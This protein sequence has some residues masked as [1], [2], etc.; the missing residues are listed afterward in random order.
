MRVAYNGLDNRAG[1]RGY[2]SFNKYTHTHAHTIPPWVD[3]CEWHRM[4]RVTG[5]D[6]T[7]MYNLIDT[8]THTHTHSE[9]FEVYLQ[10]LE[11]EI[12]RVSTA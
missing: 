2:V 6:C 4:T 10:R 12:H 5:P 7:V 1:L 9:V 3:Q 11:T 8:H